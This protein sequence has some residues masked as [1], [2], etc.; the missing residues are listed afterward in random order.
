MSV[1][2]FRSSEIGNSNIFKLPQ[3]HY[4]VTLI[5]ILEQIVIL[6]PQKLV[7]CPL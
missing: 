6:G 2:T 3:I 1:D 5:I 4:L 7:I